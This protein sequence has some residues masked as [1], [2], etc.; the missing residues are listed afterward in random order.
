M[1]DRDDEDEIADHTVRTAALPL[2]PSPNASPASP[3]AASTSQKRSSN[4][5]PSSSRASVPPSEPRA[6][7][8]S[9][10]QIEAQ[11]D[12]PARLQLIIALVLGLVLV[13]IPLYLWRRPRT[14]SIAVAVP[15][16][17]LETDASL[18]SSGISDDKPQVGD[19]RIVSCHD[20]GPHRTPSE[21][22]DHVS[23]VEKFFAKAVEENVGCVTKDNGGGTI[24][25][26][27]DISF[28]R[29]TVT[30]T[31]PRETRSMKHDKVV[32]GCQSAVKNKLQTMNLDAP[33]HQHQR[34]K[35]AVTVTY[36][37]PIKAEKTDKSDK[38]DKPDKP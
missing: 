32:A 26:L 16:A 28:K 27:A 17:G 5:P 21:Q 3:T 34:Y 11:A 37:G 9:F 23:D 8:T 14:D 33:P 30:L 31:T 25:Y 7:R 19:V 18:A 20:P 24:E 38:P 10:S 2:E 1:P 15:D 36:A 12:R 13:A 6:S 4:R 29:K 22:C 35:L